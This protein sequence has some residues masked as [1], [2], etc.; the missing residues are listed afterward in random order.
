M[1]SR[2]KRRKSPDVSYRSYEAERRAVET[3]PGLIAPPIRPLVP[4]AGQGA[5]FD[6]GEPV[7][8]ADRQ[9]D[10][11]TQRSLFGALL[12]VVVGLGVQ[13]AGCLVS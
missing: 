1:G 5:L 13:I 3:A 8:L 11:S 2:M 9:A 12:V 10:G 7:R 4:M 6:V